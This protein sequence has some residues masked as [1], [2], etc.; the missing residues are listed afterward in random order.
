MGNAIGAIA[1]GFPIEHGLGY[2]F[3]PLTG[4]GFAFLGFILLTI[5]KRKSNAEIVQP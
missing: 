2:E 4:V 5:F 3:A 1:G